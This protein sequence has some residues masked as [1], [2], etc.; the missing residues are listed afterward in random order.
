[1]FRNLLKTLACAVG[2]LV[3]AMQVAIAAEMSCP[4]ADD[5]GCTMAKGTDGKEM[6]MSV[7]GAKSGDTLD[8]ADKSG[9]MEYKKT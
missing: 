9:K 2:V 7:A 1:M 4:K 3:I 5:K 8:C 6:A